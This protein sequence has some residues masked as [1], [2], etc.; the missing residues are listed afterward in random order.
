MIPSLRQ[1]RSWSYPSKFG[2]VSFFVG[3]AVTIVLWLFPDSG[4][5]LVAHVGAAPKPTVSVPGRNAIEQQLNLAK[6]EGVTATTPSTEFA[7]AIPYARPSLNQEEMPKG[8]AG[9]LV[10]LSNASPMRSENQDLVFAPG[11]CRFLGLV[12]WADKPALRG[13]AS[14]ATISC[15]LDNGDYYGFGNFEGPDI[16]FVTQLDQPANKEL[17]LVEED[18]VVTLPKDGRYVVRFLTPLRDLPFK[19]KSVA[20]W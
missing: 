1:F 7:V 4:K 2:F 12:H 6:M 13:Q 3:L 18:K 20:T 5:Q 14:I 9:N 11:K 17:L 8:F 19:G 15:V 16:G 10:A